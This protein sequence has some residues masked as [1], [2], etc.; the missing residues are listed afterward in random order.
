MKVNKVSLTSLYLKKEGDL[1]LI[2]D[3]AKAKEIL[4]WEPIRDLSHMC[5]DGW[6]W[7]RLNPE[8]YH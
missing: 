4:N 2:A 6:K 1:S 3:N 7:K 5:I 8:G